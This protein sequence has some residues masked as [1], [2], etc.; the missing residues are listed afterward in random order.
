MVRRKND[1]PAEREIIIGTVNN[2]NPYSVFVDLDEYPDKVGM[3]HISEVARKWIRDV[4][5]WV[6]KGQ[7]V[8]CLV[9]GVDKEKGHISL[10]LKRVSDNQRNKRLQTWKRDE[11][12]E[13]LLKAIADK[14]GVTLDDVY[15]DIGFEIQENFKDMLD[16]FELAVR[17][18][19]DYIENKGIPEKWSS[20][21][22]EIASEKIKIP[23]LR[24]EEEVEVRSFDSDGIEKIKKIFND[25][26]NKNKISVSYVSAPKYKLSFKTKNPKE[27]KK[28]L[29]K[30]FDEIKEKIEEIGGEFIERTE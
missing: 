28:I 15:E 26:S 22:D 4:R 13:K 20:E 3:I 21:I 27:G 11:K 19:K 17:K 6:K 5:N 24:M 16:V 2:I 25:V 30:S 9:L 10:S 7:K 14:K 1:Y 8:V 29:R 12:G 23:N 18:G